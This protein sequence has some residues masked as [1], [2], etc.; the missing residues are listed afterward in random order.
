LGLDLSLKFIHSIN[1]KISFD[2]TRLMEKIKVMMVLHAYQP[3][4]PIQERFVVDRIVENCYRPIAMNLEKKHDVKLV[5]NMN[6]SLTEML[7]EAAPDVLDS[8]S[9]S[10]KRGNIEF[11]QSGAYHPIFP[12]ISPELANFQLEFN[13][14]INSEVFGSAYQPK[15]VWPPELAVDLRTLQLFAEKGYSYTIIPENSIQQKSSSKIPYLLH[16]NKK[17]SLIFRDK[18]LSNSISFNAYNGSIDDAVKQFRKVSS[19]THLPIVIATDMETFGEHNSDYWKFLLDLLSHPEIES[20]LYGDLESIPNTEEISEIYSSSWSTEDNHVK[21]EIPY[22]LWDHPKNPIHTIQHAHL[23]IVEHIYEKEKGLGKLT[24]DEL[25]LYLKS[26]QS[27]QFWWADQD[28]GRWSPEIISKGMELQREALFKQKNSLSAILS[29][30]LKKRLLR[31][32]N[33]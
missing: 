14:K 23:S 13:K 27:C 3:P 9:R 21:E 33:S 22:P 12:L 15:G 31:L 8:F 24:N 20:V 32:L 4:Y 30:N 25:I 26:A 16:E 6:A 2:L 18:N 29:E 17:L 28:H 7:L 19:T 1:L 10:A 5:I 11:L